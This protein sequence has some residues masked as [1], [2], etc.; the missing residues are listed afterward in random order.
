MITK[1]KMKKIHEFHIIPYFKYHTKTSNYIHLKHQ[2]TSN[3]K[4]NP[5]NKS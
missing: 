1:I 5:L 2:N 3:D 4:F